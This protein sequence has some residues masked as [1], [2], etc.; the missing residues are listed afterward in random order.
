MDTIIELKSLDSLSSAVEVN[1]GYPLFLSFPHIRQY[2]RHSDRYSDQTLNIIET[3]Y[4]GVCING[5]AR[6]LFQAHIIEEGFGCG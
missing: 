4:I 2:K 6:Q 3:P 5:R 1:Y